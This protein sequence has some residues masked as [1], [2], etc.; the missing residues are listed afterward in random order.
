MSFN[1]NSRSLPRDPNLTQ[2]LKGR[3]IS[4]VAKPEPV[5]SHADAH[6]YHGDNNTYNLEKAR[7][8]CEDQEEVERQRQQQ[9]QKYIS[10][11]S[12]WNCLW[13]GEV[14]AAICFCCICDC[15]SGFSQGGDVGMGLIP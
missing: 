15:K 12:S 14:L 9:I 11:Q 5:Y 6:T 13:V 7:S 2:S 1:Q 3:C 8:L 4:Y 10:Q